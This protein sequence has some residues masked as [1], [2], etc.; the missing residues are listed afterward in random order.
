MEKEE[1]E[2]TEEEAAEKKRKIQVR[3]IFKGVLLF[4]F[5][6]LYSVEAC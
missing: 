5:I 1:D 3:P 2:T 4:R 6:S